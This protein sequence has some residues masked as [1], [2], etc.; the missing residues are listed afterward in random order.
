MWP[1]RILGL[2]RLAMVTAAVSGITALMGSLVWVGTA[3]AA[4]VVVQRGDTLTSLAARYG[5]TPWALA[6]TN[7]L[8]DANHI[9]IGQT[10]SVPAG[11]SAASGVPGSG[12]GHSRQITVALGQTLSSIAAQY[13]VSVSQLVAANG[14]SDPN[15]VEA[16]AHLVI[17]AAAEPSG[18]STLGGPSSSFLASSYGRLLLSYFDEW[19]AHYGVPLNVLEALTWWESGWNNS[20]V[21]STGAIGIGQ[22]EPATVAYA[23]TTLTGDSSLN[24]WVASDN[25]RMA[26]AFLCHLIRH[27]PN[28]STAVAAYYQGLK[29][30]LTIGEYQ[31]TQHYV[32]GVMAYA[33]IF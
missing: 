30:V 25:I 13:G 11:P 22:L 7:D 32:A 33:R 26:A 23:R 19:S 5:T 20:E 2:R 3:H 8:S 31:D 16:G 12:A 28:V 17:P 27:T 10:L 15:L 9:E 1:V 6:Q 24:P 29:S 18:L 4:Q 14:L 21:S